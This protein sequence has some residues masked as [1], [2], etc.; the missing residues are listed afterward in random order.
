M[1][2]LLA[3]D[4]SKFSDAALQAVIAQ[5]PPQ[6]T[7]VLVLHVVEPITLSSPS[8]SVGSKVR[9]LNGEAIHL[10]AGRP[11]HTLTP[12]NRPLFCVLHAN[13][14]EGS[15]R[16]RNRRAGAGLFRVAPLEPCTGSPS[17]RL[18]SVLRGDRTDSGRQGIE[19]SLLLNA[20]FKPRLS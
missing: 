2:V 13:C 5:I 10:I 11:T 16:A 6:G 4:D 17:G 18:T 15:I 14:Q 20:H 9:H 12:L 8:R 7:E 19:N 3:V 1:Q